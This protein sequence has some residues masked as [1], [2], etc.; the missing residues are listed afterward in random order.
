MQSNDDALHSGRWINL[1]NFYMQLAALMVSDK[2]VEGTNSSAESLKSPV[3]SFVPTMADK[4]S[5]N[6]ELP[7]NSKVILT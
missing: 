2:A 4:V 5:F 6:E 7:F 3:A 1:L